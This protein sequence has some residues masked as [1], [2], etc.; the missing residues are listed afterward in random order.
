M[1]YIVV[2]LALV[3]AAWFFFFRSPA[4]NY[5]RKYK[6]K[7][8]VITGAS[9]GIG[10]ELAQKL[11]KFRPKLVIAARSEGKLNELKDICIKQGAKEVLTV[12]TDV[13]K[14]AD[15]KNLVDKAVEKFNAIDVLFLNAGVSQAAK[16]KDSTPEVLDQIMKT[17]Y[18]GAVDTAFYALPALRKSK[19][20]IVVTSSVVQRLVMAGTSAYCASKAA[21][22]AF[23]DCLRIEES[24]AGVKVTVLCPG[25]VPTGVVENSLT[26]N[27][28]K[29][30]KTKS[31][32]FRMELGPAVQLAI[33]AVASNKLEVWYTL[34]ATAIM[35]LRG[36]APNL[37]D[38]I[39]YKVR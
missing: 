26:G 8:V 10:W 3:A 18:S 31:L 29:F 30:G 6:D 16:V 27:G 14:R 9:S 4:P 38:R 23:F 7:V 28:E 21:V 24:R 2:S 36:F 32:P 5:D 25:F 13:S 17:N 39:M 37:C 12:V 20:H 19:G 34:P 1:F 22:S 35:M 33:D 11:S 15:C